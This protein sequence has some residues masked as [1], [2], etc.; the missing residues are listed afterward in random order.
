MAISSGNEV[1]ASEINNE[2]IEPLKS[3][4]HD[5]TFTDYQQRIKQNS[6]TGAVDETETQ[7]QTDTMQPY[8]PPQIGGVTAGAEANAQAAPKEIANLLDSLLNHTHVYLDDYGTACNCN[9]NCNCNC[10]RGII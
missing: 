6:K 10:T 4:S 5:H 2:V 8:T 9:C 7:S 3:L 1:K